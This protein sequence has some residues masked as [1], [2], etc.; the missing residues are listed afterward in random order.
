ML[1]ANGYIIY[2]ETLEALRLVVENELNQVGGVFNF[3][4]TCSLFDEVKLLHSRCKV[5][6]IERKTLE[7]KELTSKKRELEEITRK[8]ISEKEINLSMDRLT[9]INVL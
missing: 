3:D 1:E 6:Q 9:N 5:D 7:E 8:A 4:I 2:Q